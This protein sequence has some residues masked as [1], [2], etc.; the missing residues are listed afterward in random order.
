MIVQGVI[1]LFW[2]GS[3]G[4]LYNRAVNFKEKGVRSSPSLTASS[5]AGQSG[6]LPVSG[7]VL[8]L[9]VGSKRIG[10]AVWD[11]VGITAQGLETLQR[12]NKRTDF[13]NLERIIREYD[14]RE[15]VIGLPLR[16]SGAEGTQ[17]EKM[18]GFAEEVRKRFGLPVH[19]WDERLT[20]AEANRLLRETELSIEKRAKAVDRMA[21]VLILQGWM[22]GNRPPASGARHPADAPDL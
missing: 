19:L 8:G 3:G 10:M 7:R 20:S 14:V 22:E 4:G 18:Q 1:D 12:K 2:P 11:E 13:E 21:A 6:Q 9:D 17:A 16:M 5:S 15:I